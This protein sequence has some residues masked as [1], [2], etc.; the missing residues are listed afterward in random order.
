MHRITTLSY[1]Q[2][3]DLCHSALIHSLERF[4]VFEAS[5]TIRWNVATDTRTTPE[6]QF[7]T[8]LQRVWTDTPWLACRM[9]NILDTWLLMF[10]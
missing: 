7:N 6:P 1:P 4:A 8:Y 9:T 3:I 10:L 5:I 2:H